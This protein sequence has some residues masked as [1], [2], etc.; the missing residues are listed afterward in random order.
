MKVAILC[1]TSN[2]LVQG[3]QKVSVHLTIA[4]QSSGAQRLFDHPVEIYRLLKGT[5]HLH[6]DIYTTCIRSE[7]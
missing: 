2:I 1:V 4:V 6:L 5:C 3:D 7:K